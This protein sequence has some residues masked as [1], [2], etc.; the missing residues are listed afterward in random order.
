VLK[1]RA[2]KGW[3]GGAT[4]VV[5]LIDEAQEVATDDDATMLAIGRSLGLAMVA[6][7]QTIEGVEEKLTKPVAD[8]WL[9]VYGNVIALPGRSF[10]TD[11][12]VTK[13]LGKSWGA[14]VERVEGL[15]VRDAMRSETLTGALAASRTQESMRRWI[16]PGMYGMS[17]ARRGRFTNQLSRLLGAEGASERSQCHVGVHELVEASEVA[18]LL[19]EPNTALVVGYRA[20]VPRRDVVRLS[21]VY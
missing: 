3:L 12:F 7:T 11:E 10:R 20:R 6:A 17:S 21:P 13:R 9:N 18:T 19:A 2:E 1:E 5:F 16:G 14:K 15:T 8:K 4:P